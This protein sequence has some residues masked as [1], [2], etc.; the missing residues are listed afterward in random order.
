MSKDLVELA[1]AVEKELSQ[2]LKE[3]SK[4]IAENSCEGAV[5]RGKLFGLASYTDESIESYELGHA[6]AQGGDGAGPIRAGT[7]VV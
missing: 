7:V 2:S 1:K 5:A 3:I 4:K 6:M